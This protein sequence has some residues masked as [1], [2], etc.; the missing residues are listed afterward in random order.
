M[1]LQVRVLMPVYLD[2]YRNWRLPVERCCLHATIRTVIRTTLSVGGA[3]RRPLERYD[4]RNLINVQIC[5][6]VYTAPISQTLL[7]DKILIS[8][9]LQPKRARWSG[10][11]E[12]RWQWHAD[13]STHSGTIKSETPLSCW[14]LYS[15]RQIHW[16]HEHRGRPVTFSSGTGMPSCRK[17][18]EEGRT[19]S[20][21]VTVSVSIK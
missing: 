18:A 14:C 13:C 12:C 6:Y 1:C 16:M 19:L 17:Y 2:I 3:F 4:P 20:R 21:A 8:V 10:L 7:Y 5:T 15:Y 11:V 9:L